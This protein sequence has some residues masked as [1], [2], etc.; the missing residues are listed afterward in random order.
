MKTCPCCS[1]KS[2]KDCCEPFIITTSYP[3]T[4]EILMRSRYT[5]FALANV[6]YIF[7]TMADQ[8]L[9]SS[10]RASTQSFIDDVEWLGLEIISAAKPSS[11]E[12]EG[13]VEFVAH[14]KVNGEVKILSER[15]QFAKKEGR[16]FYVSGEH[17]LMRS[18]AHRSNTPNR[19]DPCSCGSG[20]KYKKCCLK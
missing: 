8:A 10:D 6:D 3:Q 1:G 18:V 4:P 17:K 20:I 14:Y 16:W 9:L 15:S 19:N 11:N 12:S 7:H 13:I 5:A 2:Y